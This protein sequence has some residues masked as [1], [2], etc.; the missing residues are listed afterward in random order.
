[1]LTKEQINAEIG[2]GLDERCAGDDFDGVCLDDFVAY[3]P[4]HNY[5]FLPTR[6]PWPAKSVDARIPPI[7]LVDNNGT[8]VRDDEGK[9]KRIAASKWLDQHQPVE[10]MTWCPGEP[11][12][13]EDKLVAEG[14]WI[15]RAGCTILN[16]Y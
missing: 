5:I 8:A 4:M 15:E 14:G 12:L 6:E 7:P 11:T 3:M 10:Q 9:A 13:I 2:A 1:M 16:L